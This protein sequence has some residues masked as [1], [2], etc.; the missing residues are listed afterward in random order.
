MA[1]IQVTITPLMLEAVAIKISKFGLFMNNFIS[2]QRQRVLSLIC[3]R[4]PKGNCNDIHRKGP[5]R[6]VKVGHVNRKILSTE[7]G[8]NVA[9]PSIVVSFRN[10]PI[11][12]VY[13]RSM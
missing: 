8:S 12:Q 2:A 7:D 11:D 6:H 9:G 5:R 3:K 13:L 4:E 1:T 10:L